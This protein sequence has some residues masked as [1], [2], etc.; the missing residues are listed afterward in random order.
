VIEA[1]ISG[2]AVVG[3]IVAPGKGFADGLEI[4]KAEFVTGGNKVTFVPLVPVVDH[5]D[6]PRPSVFGKLISDLFH[7]F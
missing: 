1:L 2:G 3:E 5:N 4:L 7:L 6:L